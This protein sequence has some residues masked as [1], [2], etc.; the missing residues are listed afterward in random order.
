MSRQASIP[1]ASSR[2]SARV[3]RHGGA[4]ASDDAGPAA[5]ARAA[6]RESPA[7][8]V[9]AAT[10]LA[11][12]WIFL[13]AFL[14]KLF[15]LGQATPSGAGWIDGG[16]PTEG[17]LSGATGPFAGIYHDI[18]GAGVVNWLF[19]LGLL[20]IGVAL[21]AGVAM[22]PA[23]IAG[24]LMMVLMWSSALWPETNPFM[25]DH[26]VYALVLVG[27]AL[28][29]AGDTLGLGRRWSQTALVRRLPWLA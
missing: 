21:I 22:R 7:R 4:P 28:S 18:A 25:D 11:L 17:Y 6:A 13:W 12:G 24:A 20:G 26:L 19:M 2:A 15:G 14:D 23:A 10:R 27:L 5:S 9:W 3:R 29:N 16:N 1:T 8:F